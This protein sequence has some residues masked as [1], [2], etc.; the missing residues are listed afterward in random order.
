MPLKTPE[1]NEH[2]AAST[3]PRRRVSALRARTRARDAIRDT[4]STR[5]FLSLCTRAWRLPKPL[6]Q[7]T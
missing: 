5:C 4:A 7:D 3:A 2:T 1:A 6:S